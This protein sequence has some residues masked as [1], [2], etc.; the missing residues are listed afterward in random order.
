MLLLFEHIGREFYE[1]QGGNSPGFVYLTVIMLA[2]HSFLAGAALGF[3]NSYAVM[4]VVLVAIL[5]HKWA[6]SFALS[7]KINQ[8]VLSARAGIALFLVFALMTPVGVIFGAAAT[9]YIHALPLLEPTFVA[10]AAGTFL[11]LG[12]LHGLGR[13]VMVE[14]CCNL[15]HFSFV[16]I[17]FIIM[18]VVAIWT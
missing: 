6:A 10:M 1:K 4:I 7:V 15:K 14:K 13:A 2:I 17:G 18:A 3:S 5:A 16:V 8:S 9:H 12:T 11:Y